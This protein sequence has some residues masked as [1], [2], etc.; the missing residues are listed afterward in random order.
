MRKIK[1][2][3][4]RADVRRQ[5]LT[6]LIRFGLFLFARLLQ[7]LFELINAAAGIDKLLFAGEERM[8]FGAD[9]HADV[10]FGGAGFDHFAAGAGNGGLLV[11]GMDIFFHGNH[12]VSLLLTPK[13]GATFGVYHI[14][15]QN[16]T[17]IF[18]FFSIFFICPDRAVF[19]GFFDVTSQKTVF[20]SCTSTTNSV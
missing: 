11:F 15:F 3:T 19:C 8:A 1:R 18:Q 16:A 9:L 14:L 6:R 7:T 2:V 5:N 4:F 13:R 10:L 20:C 17:K 12:L